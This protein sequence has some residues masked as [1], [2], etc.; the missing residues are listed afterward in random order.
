MNSRER[1]LTALD[2]KQPDRVPI[3]ELYINEPNIVDLARTIAPDEVKIQ[4]GRDKFGSESVEVM[5]LYCLLIERLDIDA[6]CTNFSIGITDIGGEKGRDKY[7]TYYLLSEHGEPTPVDGPIKN[8]DDLDGFDMISK[9]EES[10]FSTVQYVIEKVGKEKAHFVSITDPFKVSWRRR[11]GMQNLLMDYIQN[12]EMAHRLA[13]IATD[14]DKVAVDMIIKSGADVI[15]MPGD[16]AGEDTT[17]MS[18]THFREYIK[19]YH[20]EIVDYVHDKGLKIIK[21]SDGNLWPILDD[22]VEVGFDGLHPIQPQCMD[23]GEVKEYLAGKVCILGNIDC[24]DLLVNGT[25]EEVEETVKQTIEKAAPGGGYI[26]TSSNS[27]HPGVKTENYLAMVEAV[28][29]YGH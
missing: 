5:D 17:I 12:P 19:P 21:H 28:H 26:I 4:A 22:L 1:I 3:F 9:L 10:D 13:C 2:K 27:I 8:M 7:G 29:K 25:V 6:T 15:T 18:P 24:R 20:K 16:L 23:I 11:G 14:F